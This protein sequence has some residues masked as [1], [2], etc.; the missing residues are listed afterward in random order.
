MG[1]DFTGK[2]AVV[3]GGSRGIGFGIAA[4]FAEAGADVVLAA[5]SA[6]NLEAAADAIAARA[7]R[8]PSVVAAD[9][10]T[11][12]GCQSVFDAVMARHGRCEILVNSAGATRAGS[13]LALTDEQWQD[14]FDLKFFACV[15][16]SRL[17]WPKLT[18]A[19][20]HVVNVIGAAALTPDPGF[21]IGGS[22]NAA[23]ANFTKGLS[24]LGK[25]AGV[26]V[27]AI[28]PGMTETDRVGQLF[29]Q[30]AAMTGRTAAEIRDEFIA[31]DGLQRLGRPEDVAAL[32][33]FL[34]SEAARHIQGVAIAVDGGATPGVH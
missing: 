20:G 24:G 4:A 25:Q 34:C 32:A 17:F 13:F 14:G 18:E 2:V 12:S 31:K 33:L 9:L 1:M 16:L 23:M 6:R 19:R 15:R 3:S 29:E 11:A 27:N 8:K 21:L 26:N 22:V 10:R 7:G 28:H 5:S 30:R